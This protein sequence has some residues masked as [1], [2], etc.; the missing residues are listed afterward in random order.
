MNGDVSGHKTENRVGNPEHT[1]QT[2]YLRLPQGRN[3][4]VTLQLTLRDG[5]DK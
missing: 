4:A 1:V 5:G 2:A 3:L